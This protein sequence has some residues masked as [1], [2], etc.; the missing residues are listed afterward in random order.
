MHKNKI[1]LDILKLQKMENDKNDVTFTQNIVFSPAWYNTCI[2][3][4]IERSI[5]FQRFQELK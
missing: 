2:L 4:N 1:I 5:W 3:D